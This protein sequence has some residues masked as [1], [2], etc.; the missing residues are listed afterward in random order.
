MGAFD[1]VGLSESRCLHLHLIGK[2]KVRFF[3]HGPIIMIEWQGLP[4]SSR[5]AALLFLDHCGAQQTLLFF[6]D[7][8]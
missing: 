2:V 6:F 5:K 4:Y 8:S 7:C 1:K 3:G